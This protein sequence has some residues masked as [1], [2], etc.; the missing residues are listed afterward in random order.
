MGSLQ[1]YLFSKPH[2][3]LLWNCKPHRVAVQQVRS[4][5]ILTMIH[6]FPVHQ[7][8]LGC[9]R[10]SWIPSEC[11]GPKVYEMAPGGGYVRVQEH[12]RKTE[13]VQS[14]PV[15]KWSLSHP[16][17]IPRVTQSR[18]PLEWR[19]LHPKW[20]L[21]LAQR[22]YGSPHPSDNS[23]CGLPM[24]STRVP[25]HCAQRSPRDAH[26]EENDSPPHVNT[27]RFIDCHLSGLG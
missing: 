13:G 20:A 7:T 4:I 23:P 11:E 21:A 19:F 27:F 18:V 6:C 3:Q 16:P 17:P 8:H 14:C 22:S 25:M 10:W 5:D 9:S 15:T 2:T 24:N 12:F 26:E 1:L